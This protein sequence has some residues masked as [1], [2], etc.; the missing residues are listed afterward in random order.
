MAADPSTFSAG[1]TFLRRSD[2]VPV[3]MTFTS[4]GEPL[5]PENTTAADYTVVFGPLPTPAAPPAAAIPPAP[6]MPA[7]ME[8][9]AHAIGKLMEATA[10]QAAPTAMVK[11]ESPDKF[12]GSR[13]KFDKWLLQLRSNFNYAPRQFS[14]DQ[15]QNRVIYAGSL[16]TG[17]PL[18]WYT[19]LVRAARIY[20]EA[21][22]DARAAMVGTEPHK[23]YQTV[24][25]WPRFEAALTAT[26][27][28]PHR[29][30]HLE[31]RLLKLK[32]TGS[33]TKYVTEFQSMVFAIDWSTST[34]M[35]NFRKG[36]KHEVRIQLALMEATPFTRP[37]TLADLMSAAIR[38]DNAIYEARRDDDEA[39]TD[40]RNDTREALASSK[41]AR[42]SN[43]A[44][45]KQPAASN[46][47]GDGAQPR[48]YS[49]R[50]SP[51]PGS[52]HSYS[53][54]PRGSP[55]GALTHPARNR[56]RN[57]FQPGNATHARARSNTFTAFRSKE[58][59]EDAETSDHTDGDTS[60]D[61][62]HR[63]G[64]SSSAH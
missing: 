45:E 22:P 54:T 39:A 17:T 64:S 57:V 28:D 55:A 50:S 34:K 33:A 38:I 26:F 35:R 37:Q 43:N 52:P 56:D 47:S 8:F 41:L 14:L 29:A 24:N 3:P 13:D 31:E 59:E 49:H 12:D 51:S 36:L 21:G 20:G 58:D 42:F 30:E 62:S 32:Q 63:S 2:N 27:E 40:T 16:L 6:S 1:A 18:D 5:C 10:A 23:A 25:D 4:Q 11:I 7:G 60:D 44:G 19:A 15:P 53:S 61:E 9:L 48:H 46:P